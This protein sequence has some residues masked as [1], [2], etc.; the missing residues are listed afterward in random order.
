[1]FAVTPISILMLYKRCITI[2][3]DHSPELDDFEGLEAAAT[4]H[5]EL[6]NRRPSFRI[7]CLSVTIRQVAY[8][9][10]SECSCGLNIQNKIIN[11][12]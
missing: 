3:H 12:K 1:M 7:V 10:I 5:L 6:L 9:V 4:K 2:K 8:G 11:N